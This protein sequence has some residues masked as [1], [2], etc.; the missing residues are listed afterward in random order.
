MYVYHIFFV[1][2]AV[3]A[4]VGCFD[5]LAIIN[6]ATVNIGVC[7]SLKIIVSSGYMPGNGVTGSYYLLFLVFLR[8]LHTVLYSGC[9]NLHSHQQCRRVHFSPHP[10][11]H[12]LFVY[13]LIMAIMNSLL[14][15]S[16]LN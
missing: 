12:L 9:T 13:F 7:V 16:D 1:H 6:T 8:N 2:S 10:L 11:K 4:N 14:P 5:I 15:N 3:N